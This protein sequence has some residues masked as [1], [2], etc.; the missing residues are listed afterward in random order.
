MKLETLQVENFRSIEDSTPFSISDV[1][2]LVGK[3]EA[4]KSALL[5]ALHKLNP[6]VEADE[7]KEE[8]YP[9]RHHTDYEAKVRKDP[10]AAA[11]KPKIT[12][13]SNCARIASIGQ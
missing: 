2:C 7:F 13:P 6:V 9:R 3:N 11:L 12:P 8:D 1:T 10:S 5:Q 4:G